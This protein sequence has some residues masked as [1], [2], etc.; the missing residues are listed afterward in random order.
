[1]YTDSQ[2]IASKLVCSIIYLFFILWLLG[3]ISR[4]GKYNN[5]ASTRRRRRYESRGG[6]THTHMH[7]THTHTMFERGNHDVNAR[8]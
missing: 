2:W 4:N 8:K 6:K 5:R 1:M 7:Q 3:G